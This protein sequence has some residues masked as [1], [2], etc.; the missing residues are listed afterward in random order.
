MA[1]SE[2]ES[3]ELLELKTR[4]SVG[5][6]CRALQILVLSEKES[7]RAGSRAEAMEE[8]SWKSG[9]HLSSSCFQR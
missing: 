3:M 4:N 8:V 9:G 6:E 1:F 7:R 5:L 2:N